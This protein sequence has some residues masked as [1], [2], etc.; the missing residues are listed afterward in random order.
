MVDLR[1][2]IFSMMPR[3]QLKHFKKMFE[4]MY[5]FLIFIIVSVKIN[6]DSDKGHNRDY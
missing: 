4:D 2:D 3:N 6:N 1:F 5:I